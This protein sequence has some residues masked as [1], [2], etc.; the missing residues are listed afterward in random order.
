[1]FR[2]FGTLIVIAIMSVLLV[3][4][5]PNLLQARRPTRDERAAMDTKMAVTQARVYASD[6]GVYP[7][8]IKA[9]VEG[10]AIYCP[11][12]DKD[13]WGNDYVLSPVLTEGRTPRE[14]DNVYVFSRGP[15]GTGVYP[16]PF[17]HDTGKDG[18]IG[19]SSVH[20]PWG[21]PLSRVEIYKLGWFDLIG[22]PIISILIVVICVYLLIKF[23]AL[24]TGLL[25]EAWGR[26]WIVLAAIC[27]VAFLIFAAAGGRSKEQFFSLL[28]GVI[29]WFFLFLLAPRRKA[30]SEDQ[31]SRDDSIRPTS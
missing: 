17:T 20:G 22:I 6:N 26:S 15:K 29:F 14:G 31:L 16:Q 11:C 9:L 27:N 3:I 10:K 24:L 4:A 23:I 1:M 2:I 5:I 28:V 7:T 30:G 8:S 19:Y 12:S 21:T 18:S 13:S 25:V